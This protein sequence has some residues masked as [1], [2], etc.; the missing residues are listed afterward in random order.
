LFLIATGLL[1]KV[2]IG[3]YLALNLVDRIFDAPAQYSALECYVG[4]V[5][6]AIQI[7]CDFSG[8]TDIAIGSALLLG[9]RFPLNFDA[10]YKAH[11]ISNFWRRWH[12]SLSTWLRDY[13]YIPLG[14]NRKGQARTYFN[15]MATMLLG[16]LWHGAS[17]TFVVWGGIHG[18]AL[19][20]TR[21]YQEWRERRGIA[22]NRSAL[23]H[24]ACVIAT[25]HL[26]LVAWVFFRAE[27][28]QKAAQVFSQLGTLTTHHANLD[29]RLLGVL[30]VGLVTHWL[31]ESWYLKSRESFVR[32]PAPAQGAALFCAA[33]ALREMAS[34]EA[35]PFV[36]F[37]F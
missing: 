35:V 15:L 12:I 14:G 17:W 25:F 10:P 16:G 11:N 37:Q 26:V 1:K 28:F 24:A 8:Y 29:P 20:L 19:S 34:A 13:L 27:T 3:D 36:Y 18:A 9:V 33:L 31:P 5:G 32:M 4:V 21:M 22:P 6:Y 30:A 7:Y 2:A 23:V